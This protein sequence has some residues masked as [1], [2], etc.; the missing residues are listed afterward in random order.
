M[1]HHYRRLVELRHTLPVVVA[2]D[3]RLL[4]PDDEQVFADVRSLDGD[5]LLALANLS[6]E[7]AEVGLGADSA[8]LT[9]DVFLAGGAADTAKREGVDAIPAARGPWESRVIRSR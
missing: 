6:G 8:L 2:G 7:P 5:H 3:Y 1:F 4:M 9:G